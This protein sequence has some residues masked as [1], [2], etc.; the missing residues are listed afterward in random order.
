MK[1]LLVFLLSAVCLLDCLLLTFRSNLTLGLILMYLLTAAL[2]LYG[3]HHAVVDAF[4]THGVG[5]V[6][7][8]G[9]FLGLCLFAVLCLC[10][11]NRAKTTA[12][13]RETAV[14]I[15][16]AGL[17]GETVSDTLARRLDAALAL[18]GKR[19]DVLYVVS[20]GQGPQE[21]CTEA[22]AMAKY[23]AVRGVDPGQILLEDRSRSTREN[24]LY[25]REV[26]RQAGVSPTDSIAFVTNDFHCLRSGA[27]GRL[28][29]F[30]SI[31]CVSTS[32]SPVVLFPALMR[33][34]LAICALWARTLF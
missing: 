12:T 10:I 15:L 23:L 33:E 14:I 19:S 30:V 7:R 31:C 32:T 9:F 21:D 4:C 25:S 28:A 3:R 29:G 5:R 16:G 13:G 2:F 27:Y 6:L 1:E 11:A 22:S 8:A 34:A 20:G 26:L 24:F 18:Y 17:H